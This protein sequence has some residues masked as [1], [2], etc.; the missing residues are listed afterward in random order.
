MKHLKISVTAMIAVIIALAGSA[1]TIKHT[2]APKT[3]TYYYQYG[4]NTSD[5]LLI[6][7]NWQSVSGP[8]VGC[9][10]S[11]VN[12]VIHLSAGPD[13]FGN[14]DFDAA[15]ISDMDALNAV[16]NSRKN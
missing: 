1:F 8:S 4:P 11:G 12:C 7:S 10:G 15:G 5:G 9:S 16:T 3:T 6:E 14:P 2:P 13:Q